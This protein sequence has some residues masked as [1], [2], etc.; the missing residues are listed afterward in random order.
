MWKSYPS[1]IKIPLCGL[2]ILIQF[3]NTS[4][5]CKGSLGVIWNMWFNSAVMLFFLF[6][7]HFLNLFRLPR[8]SQT[9]TEPLWISRWLKETS[10]GW[11]GGNNWS[12]V[13][14]NKAEPRRMLIIFEPFF[15]FA[16]ISQKWDE[17]FF[18]SGQTEKITHALCVSI[19]LSTHFAFVPMFL[20]ST[21]VTG[22]V[23]ALQISL[24]KKACH[25]LERHYFPQV[26]TLFYRRSIVDP[27]ENPWSSHVQWSSG[28]SPCYPECGTVS[29]SRL[30]LR[31]GL[32]FTVIAAVFLT[33]L[34]CLK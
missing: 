4:N 7:F 5:H 3:R 26:P 2:G 18:Q 22:A 16:T 33:L 1:G 23:A 17:L 20:W 9:T 32:T 31:P 10:V 11:N 6:F 24:T 30:T 12:W 13:T 25:G 8:I 21:Q 14:G 29:T 19:T 27:E 28:G 34:L 15:F